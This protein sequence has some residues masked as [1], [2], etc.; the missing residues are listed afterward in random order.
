MNECE[1]HEWDDDYDGIT[2]AKCGKVVEAEEFIK[3]EERVEELEGGILAHMD[4]IRLCHFWSEITGFNSKLWN[5]VR[6]L[7]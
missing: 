5:L 3:L 4:S 2:C 1:K 7:R 6:G